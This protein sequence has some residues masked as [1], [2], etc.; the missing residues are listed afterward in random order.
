M[1][2]KGIFCYFHYFPLHMSNF[3]KKFNNKKLIL[4]ENVWKGLVRLPIYP[5]LNKS[6]IKF[7][8][9]TARKFFQLL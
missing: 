2:R 5:D 1:K 4:T 8:T 6:E 7:I 3:G 9:I